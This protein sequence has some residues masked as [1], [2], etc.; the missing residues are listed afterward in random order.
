MKKSPAGSVNN[1]LNSPA[2]SSYPIS[3]PGNVIFNVGGRRFE[4]SFAILQKYP[5]S[6]LHRLANGLGPLSLS[7]ISNSFS[8][9]EVFLDHNPDAFQCVLD[10]MRYGG[11]VLVPRSVCRDVVVLQMKQFGLPVDHIEEPSPNSGNDL[12]SYD[13]LMGLSGDKKGEKSASG[14][15]SYGKVNS[16]MAQKLSS[17]VNML[18]YPCIADYARQGYIKVYIYLTD[19]QIQ[20]SNVASTIEDDAPVEWMFLGNQVR[21]T[22]SSDLLSGGGSASAESAIEAMDDISQVQK[23][24]ILSVIRKSREAQAM[25]SQTQ[26]QITDLPNTAYLLQT[27]VLPLLQDMTRSRTTSVGVQ[28]ERRDLTVRK[29]NEFGLMESTDVVAIKILVRIA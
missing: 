23:N 2:S 26:Q 8:G 29:E 17:L 1:L 6:Q 3:H 18:L 27:G 11:R 12:P 16:V 15:S 28:A 10:Y 20:A 14:S 24:R 22:R 25:Q 19:Q 21:K 7:S 13:E 5:D 9:R 4:I